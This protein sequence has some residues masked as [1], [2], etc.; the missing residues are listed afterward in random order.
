MASANL[1]WTSSNSALCAIMSAL[2]TAQDESKL[3]I[4]VAL[5]ERYWVKLEFQT[6]F[7][8]HL[9]QILSE[10]L[11]HNWPFYGTLNLYFQI[12]IQILTS[13]ANS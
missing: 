12:L 9:W 3:I 2:L 7:E 6:S 5:F 10:Y 1:G 13:A 8:M 11:S 4:S